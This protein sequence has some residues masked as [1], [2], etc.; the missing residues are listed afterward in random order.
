MRLNVFEDTLIQKELAVIGYD[1]LRKSV[2]RA[3]WSTAE[4][5][6]FLYFGQD[7]RQY[8]TAQFGL[9]NPDAQKFGI[10]AM[11]K[12]GHPNFQLWAKERD[13]VVEC[14]MTFHFA[15]L[16]KFSRTSFPRVRV[17]DTSGDELVN[18]V[19]GFVVRNLLPIIKSIIDLETYLAFLVAD[20][21]PNRWLVSSNHMIR[22]AQIVAVAA[23]LGRSDAEI[24]ELLKP[25]DCQIEKR[26]R[27]I[28]NDTVTGI[29]MYVDKL[30][31]DW[32]LRA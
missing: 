32:A 19:M 30:L 27:H 20:L 18:L 26:M 13:V 12:Y 31:S 4:V 28:A 1:R 3:T 15:S 2:Y 22:V 7:S 10:E 23:Q 17:P 9:R 29:D 24:K 25:Y 5:E 11:V 21:E 8:F 6:H 16:D 14:S